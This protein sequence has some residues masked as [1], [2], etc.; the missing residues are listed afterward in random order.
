VKDKYNIQ[1][2]MMYCLI[3]ANYGLIKA[4]GVTKNPAY[5]AYRNFVAANP[6]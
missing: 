4:D 1:C 5:A 3:D 6:V 2:I